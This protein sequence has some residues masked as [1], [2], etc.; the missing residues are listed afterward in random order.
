MISTW[1]SDTDLI[2]LETIL[3]ICSFPSHLDICWMLSAKE[4]ISIHNC[5]EFSRIPISILLLSPAC[6]CRSYLQKIPSA[7]WCWQS[8]RL[9]RPPPP[10]RN[11]QILEEQK[12][13]ST[14]SPCLWFP[15]IHQSWNIGIHKTRSSPTPLCQG[16]LFS[17]LYIVSTSAHGV[18]RS[19][20][21]VL[22]NVL[23]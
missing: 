18:H 13:M 10:L 21:I 22:L 11:F 23:S 7:E 6:R 15:I 5:S 1:D 14:S 8:S 12:K 2:A 4:T 17:Y 16:G 9:M 3:V 19:T 20:A